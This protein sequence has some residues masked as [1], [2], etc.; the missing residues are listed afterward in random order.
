MA[1]KGPY[2]MA[3][4]YL[5]NLILVLNT[6]EVLKE[7]KFFPNVVPGTGSIQEAL[8][9]LFACT[10]TSD[11]SL[12]ITSSERLIMTPLPHLIQD[13]IQIA[14]LTFSTSQHFFT[15]HTFKSVW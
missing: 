15:I 13:S 8:H 3:S 2:N 7:A 1:C 12:N 4:A 14:P 6:T 5:S 10:Y 9:S 11:L